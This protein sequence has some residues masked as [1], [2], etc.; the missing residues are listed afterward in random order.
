[1]T[2]A[3]A[4]IERAGLPVTVRRGRW[5]EFTVRL[6]DRVIARR[7]WLRAPA[8]DMVLDVLAGRISGAPPRRISAR[9]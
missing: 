6:D 1:M 2:M 4:I 5:G 3:T 9:S 8:I 7:R